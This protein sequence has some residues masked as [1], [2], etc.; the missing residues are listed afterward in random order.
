MRDQAVFFLPDRP[1]SLLSEVLDL[2]GGLV[3]ETAPQL[4]RPLGDLLRLIPP[5]VWALCFDGDSV[6]MR[7]EEEPLT[8]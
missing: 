4:P 2:A 6:L 7:L 5:A 8:P 1:R 3:Q